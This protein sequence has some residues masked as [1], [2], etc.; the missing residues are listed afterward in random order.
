MSCSQLCVCAH[1]H[2]YTRVQLTCVGVDIDMCGCASNTKKVG[3]PTHFV[4]ADRVHSHNGRVSQ[5]V[6]HC[7]ES[8]PVV[9]GRTG[10]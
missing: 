9:H 6:K 7:L 1:I 2:V 3:A 5:P 4:H 8:L 10:T